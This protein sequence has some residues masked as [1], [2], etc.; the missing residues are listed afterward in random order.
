M[1]AVLCRTLRNL[2]IVQSC[3]LSN[4]NK[5]E[6]TTNNSQYEN[7]KKFEHL[8][9]KLYAYREKNLISERSLHWNSHLRESYPIILSMDR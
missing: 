9:S 2:R 7:L 3:R 1:P 4:S 5:S 8:N 6:S